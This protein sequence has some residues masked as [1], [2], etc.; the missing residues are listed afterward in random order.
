MT[1]ARHKTVRHKIKDLSETVE[2]LSQEPKKVLDYLL[3]NTGTAEHG[4]PNIKL[5]TAG[6][7]KLVKST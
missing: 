1:N 2:I 4:S 7:N 3:L 6:T 5:F